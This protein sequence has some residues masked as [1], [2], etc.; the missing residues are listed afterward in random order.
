MNYMKIFKFLFEIPIPR[1]YFYHEHNI[2]TN[3]LE[4]KKICHSVSHSDSCI[5]RLNYRSKDQ[6]KASFAMHL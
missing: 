4:T 2:K 6:I 5:S 1:Y 3:L